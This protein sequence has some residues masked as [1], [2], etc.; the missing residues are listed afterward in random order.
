MGQALFCYER[1]WASTCHSNVGVS[2]SLFC[3]SCWMAM[4]EAMA[5]MRGDGCLKMGCN[6]GY[7]YSLLCCGEMICIP[8]WLVLYSIWQSIGEHRG[9]IYDVDINGVGVAPQGYGG[10]PYG[11]QPYGGRPY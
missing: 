10:Q 1:S 11:G 6:Q 4:P 8:E 9:R 3:C 5:Q 7:G 2:L